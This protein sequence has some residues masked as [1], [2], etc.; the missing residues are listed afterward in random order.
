MPHSLFLA[1]RISR[2]RHQPWHLQTRMSACPLSPLTTPTQAHQTRDNARGGPYHASCTLTT[3]QKQ[4]KRLTACAPLPKQRALLT[5]K[6]CG[7]AVH[8]DSIYTTARFPMCSHGTTQC[9]I[10]HLVDSDAACTST[11]QLRGLRETILQYTSGTYM[12]TMYKQTPGPFVGSGVRGGGGVARCPMARATWGRD[13]RN[14][15]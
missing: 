1:P 12:A 4:S 2:H 7:R 14:W 8:L 6:R 9:T 11:T 15:S 3:R 10:L 13:T 5:T